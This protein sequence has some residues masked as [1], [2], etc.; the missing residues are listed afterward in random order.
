MVVKVK[1]K[2]IKQTK[3]LKQS[4]KEPLQ[5]QRQ[6]ITVNIH[7][8]KKQVYKRRKQ[9]KKVDDE[10]IYSKPLPPIN[11]FYPVQSILT[12]PSEKEN[13][14][15]VDTI[16]N[17][18][19]KEETLLKSINESP[20]EETP[21]QEQQKEEIPKQKPLI[22]ELPKQKPL[23][24]EIPKQEPKEDLKIMSTKIKNKPLLEVLKSEEFTP[25]NNDTIEIKR[26]EKIKIKQKDETP[27][28]EL[29]KENI[30]NLYN[31][32]LKTV[33][34]W[35]NTINEY[36]KREINVDEAI[37][38]L[39]DISKDAKNKSQFIKKYIDTYI[40]KKNI[41]NKRPSKEDI[42]EKRLKAIEEQKI[43]TSTFGGRVI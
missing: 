30:Q 43:A 42:R 21:K 26:G 25:F 6:H 11:Y 39:N 20:K 13:K 34:R 27:N 40:K 7:E 18:Q 35:I 31:P 10:I 41:E 37:K 19:K 5:T 36:E 15:L 8:P 33:E 1:T 17:E 28:K 3:K 9:I 14:P 22:E 23:M 38:E 29:I 12:P 2:K 24:E 4:K 16:K 32:N